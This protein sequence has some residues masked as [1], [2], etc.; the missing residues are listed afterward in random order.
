MLLVDSAG[1]LPPAVYA[2][3]CVAAALALV[4]QCELPEGALALTLTLPLALTLTLTLALTLTLPLTPCRPRVA[5]LANF[6]EGEVAEMVQL[7]T[8]KGLPEPKARLANP[9][10][11]RDRV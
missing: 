11:V 7:Y 1:V 2:S 4:V 3:P 10:L 6:P 8:K 5:E 9:N